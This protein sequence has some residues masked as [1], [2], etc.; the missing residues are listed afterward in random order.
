MNSTKGSSKTPRRTN[1]M[2]K[3]ITNYKERGD[4]NLSGATPRRGKAQ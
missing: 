4:F 2:K 3:T 1:L